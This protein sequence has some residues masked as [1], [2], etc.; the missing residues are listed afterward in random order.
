MQKRRLAHSSASVIPVCLH[1]RARARRA[2]EHNVAKVAVCKFVARH[3]IL[4]IETA[5]YS[6]MDNIQSRQRISL[7][8]IFEREICNFEG[9]VPFVL[10]EQ[11]L[12]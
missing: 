8:E 12:M 2:I 6:V 11:I 5:A 9:T 4:I 3:S 1:A 10:L 7:R